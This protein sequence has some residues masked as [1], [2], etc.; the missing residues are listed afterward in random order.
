MI[1]R[2]GIYISP[3]Q[4]SY[5]SPWPG[6]RAGSGGG[7]DE[8]PHDGNSLCS[9][10]HSFL[11]SNNGLHRRQSTL[12]LS[13]LPQILSLSALSLFAAVAALT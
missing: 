10:N 12:E 9:L 2:P 7:L 13:L 1:E 4:V 5:L 3:Y 6:A 8:P 11:T